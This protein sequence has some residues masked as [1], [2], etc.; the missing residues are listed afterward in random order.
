MHASKSHDKVV[1]GSCVNQNGNYDQ[2]A[3]LG[4]SQMGNSWHCTA[5]PAQWCEQ[6]VS[7]LTLVSL[8]WKGSVC[9]QGLTKESW[10]C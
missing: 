6:A 3:D 4:R 9:L 7:P 10:C 1:N 8:L 5:I 2:F